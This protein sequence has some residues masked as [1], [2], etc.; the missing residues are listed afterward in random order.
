MIK[1]PASTIGVLDHS[2]GILRANKALSAF[3]VKFFSKIHFLSNTH[4]T[5]SVWIR[6]KVGSQ[7]ILF[8]W[9]KI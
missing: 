9:D 8:L 5:G 3:Q 7:Y 4:I 1:V 2:A 6:I